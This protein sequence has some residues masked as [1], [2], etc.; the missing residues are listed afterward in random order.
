MIMKSF[1][2]A[3]IRGYQYLISPMLGNSCRF[4]PS[5]SAYAHEAFLAYPIWR[6]LGLTCKRLL[7][8]HPFCEG[9]VD[10]LPEPTHKN[11]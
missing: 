1:I 6:A 10:P 5:C 4:Y 11:G 8:C 2:I 7:R 9:G 3:M